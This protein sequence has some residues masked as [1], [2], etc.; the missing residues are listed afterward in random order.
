MSNGD[1]IINKQTISRKNSPRVV[2]LL[3]SIYSFLFNVFHSGS[4]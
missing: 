2:F 3:K 4:I 1:I